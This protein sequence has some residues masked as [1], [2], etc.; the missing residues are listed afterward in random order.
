MAGSKP[1]DKWTYTVHMHMRNHGSP[2]SV[3]LAQACL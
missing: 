1:T 2:A 3:G